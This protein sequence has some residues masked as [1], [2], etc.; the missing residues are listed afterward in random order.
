MV[1]LRLAVSWCLAMHTAVKAADCSLLVSLLT[2]ARVAR[3]CLRH[4]VRRSSQLGYF[5]EVS[6]D[7]R[8]NIGLALVARNSISL[9][10]LGALQ[11]GSV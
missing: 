11:D 3:C 6:C 1:E 8:K 7:S 5:M 4:D 9:L 10:R 2:L